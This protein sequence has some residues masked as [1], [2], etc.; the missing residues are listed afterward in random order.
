MYNLMIQAHGNPSPFRFKFE[1]VEEAFAATEKALEQGFYRTKELTLLLGA[2]SVLNITSD[3]GEA[4]AARAVEEAKRSGG[5]I[6]NGRFDVQKDDFILH[7]QMGMAQLPLLI[8]K[9]EAERTKAI[10]EAL[11]TKRLHYVFKQGHDHLFVALGSGVALMNISGEKYI[12]MRRE[13]I[14][15]MQRQM[16]AA[17]PKQDPKL[18]LPFSR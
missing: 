6:Q 5:L 16:A 7:I 18:V 15:A 12:A 4:E 9:V 2:G 11:S 17:A 1:K 8:Y 10:D 14:A 3:E 13:A